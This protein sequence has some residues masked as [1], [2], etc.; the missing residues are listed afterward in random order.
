MVMATEVDMAVMV[1]MAATV[2]TAVTPCR[3]V[4]TIAVAATW[5]VH[6]QLEPPLA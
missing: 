2:A 5:R 4:M 3:A 6:W 1:A